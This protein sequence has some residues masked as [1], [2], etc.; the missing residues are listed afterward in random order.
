M[1]NN[2]LKEISS[3]LKQF[4]KKS[5]MVKISV[6]FLVLM[7]LNYIL[8]KNDFLFNLGQISGLREGMVNNGGKSLVY[9]HM[10]GCPF[11]QK[12]DGGWDKFVS[13]NKTSIKT[14]R[15]ESKEP[16]AQK[17]Q[18]PGY[19]CVYLL[20]SNGQKIDEWKDRK[21]PQSA[22]EQANVDEQ[23]CQSLLAY[24]QSKQ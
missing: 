10:E 12:F 6:V 18:I 21:V 8:N 20:D 9:F 14:R 23:N 16:E 7:G 3:L 1:Y 22:S 4:K 13:Q 2:V 5:F 24:C 15:C 11:C 17:M 19:P